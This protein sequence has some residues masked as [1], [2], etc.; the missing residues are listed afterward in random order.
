MG[1][2]EQNNKRIARNALFLYIRQFLVMGITLFTSR[3]VLREL[4]VL[5]YGIYN[6]VGGIVAM[7]G[8]LNTS[9]SV[10]SQRYITFALGQ[11]NLEKLKTVFRSS[12]QGYLFLCI[13]LLILAET[14]GVWFINNHLV[15]PNS[16]I[17]AA[18]WVFQ[19]SI[20][21]CV[22]ALLTNSYNACII[23]HEHMNVYAYISVIEVS[24]KLF[25]A[26]SLTV[27]QYDSLIVYG[28][29]ILLCQI[30]ISIIYRI[31]CVN[32]FQECR[33]SFLFDKK[34]FIQLLS[35]SGWNLLGSIATLL[36]TQGLNI[37]LNMFFSPVI[38]ASRGIAVQ[39]NNAISQFFSNF[40]TAFRPQ[41]TKYYAKGDMENVIKLINKSSLYSYF[42]IILLALPI[43]LETPTIIQIWLSQTPSYVISFTRLIILITVCDAM[44]NPLMT[45]MQAV[46]DLKLYQGVLSP[47]I[48]L[49]VPLSYVA[50]TVIKDPNVVF[51]IS[52]CLSFVCLVIRILFV[53]RYVKNFKLLIYLKN[54]YGRGLLVTCI[55]IIAPLVV[56]AIT[57]E[58]LMNFVF[59]L[60]TC[61]T[62]TMIAIYTLGINKNERKIIN[63]IFLKKILRRKKL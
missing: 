48:L 23:A 61:L 31:Y 53:S 32:K 8:L 22:N 9:M 14:I 13:I 2:F 4:G 57:E 19:L 10:A 16:R 41:I 58:T 1:N 55:A 47:I 43:L 25:V 52:L 40:Y 17:V 24:L 29:L 42:L 15:I 28:L 37:V 46:G 44:S 49:N 59:R 20:L 45:V 12:F 63:S 3:I 39:V 56:H 51:Y 21:A 54:V 18:N 36:K 6:V 5:D 26:Y 50:L 30:F 35:F 38:N 60:I 7:M 34:T 33:V 11:G 27:I 62:S